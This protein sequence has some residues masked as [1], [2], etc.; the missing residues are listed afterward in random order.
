MRSTRF[1][2]RHSGY[3]NNQQYSRSKVITITIVITRISSTKTTNKYFVSKRICINNVCWIVVASVAG[4]WWTDIHVATTTTLI[5]IFI[6]QPWL[7]RVRRM[8]NLESGVRLRDDQIVNHF[9]NHYE[10][11]RK[12]LMV[13]NIK[14]FRKNLDKHG[15]R[16]VA[17]LM[18][19]VPITFNLP[20][21]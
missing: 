15:K 14:R 7:A 21:E 9:P 6:G 11:T 3:H 20:G 4:H 8:F 18:D 1:S 2:S 17:Q 12:D 16:R 5:G 19:F 10:L 13:K